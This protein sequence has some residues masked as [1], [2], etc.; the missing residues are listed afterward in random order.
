MGNQLAGIAPSQIFPVEHYLTDLAEFT[1][2]TNLGSTRFFKVAKAKHKEGFTVVKVFA[3]HDPSLPLSSHKERLEVIRKSLSNIPNCLP[4]QKAWLTEKAGILVRQFV[5]DNLYDRLSTRPFL[6]N[7][8]KRWIAFQL[9]D[10]LSNCHKLGVC[11]GDIK[12]ENV[13]VTGWNWV[14]LTDFASYKPTYL[15]EDNPADFSYFFDTSRRRTCYIAPERFVKTLHMDIIASS[16]NSNL[17][18]PEDEIKKGDLTPAMDIFSLGCVLTELFTDGNAP[19]DFSQLLAY[20]S[21]E[22]NPTKILDKIEDKN[23]KELVK[24]MIQKDPTSRKSAQ[25]YLDQQ[26]NFAFPDYFYSFLKEYVQGFSFIPILAPDDKI[27]RLKRDVKNIISVLQHDKDNDD[28]TLS[29]STANSEGLVIVVSLVTSCLRA[30]KHC[31]A[32]LQALEVLAEMAPF[33]APEII[34][35][36]LLP[37]MLFLLND[38]YPRVRVAAIEKLTYCLTLVK[39]IP[40]SDAN[41]FP[42]YIFPILSHVAQD[43]AVIVRTS[44]AENIA[45]I[46][47]TALRFLELTQLDSEQSD[48]SQAPSHPASYD[49]ELQILQEMVQDCVA[50]LLS[51]P[52]NV[53][54]QML[55]EQGITRL[56]VFFGRQKANDI[57]LSHMITFLNDKGD[58]NLRRVFF[59]SI[60][61]IAAY[62]GWQCCPILKPL[63]QQGLAD[64]EEFVI[65]KTLNSMADLAELGLIQK[66]MLYEFI[67]ET[68]PFLCHP[69]LWI[70]HGAVGFVCA[71]AKTLSLADLQCKLMPLLQPFLSRNVIQLDSEVV[72]LD[73][74]SEPLTREQ[75]DYLVKLPMLQPFLEDLRERQLSQCIVGTSHKVYM[76]RDSSL[77]TVYRRLQSEGISDVGLLEKKILA[78]SDHLLKIHKYFSGD[79]RSAVK[80]KGRII[81]LAQIGH[82]VRLHSRIIS[83]SDISYDQSQSSSYRKSGKKKMN[84][85][86]SPGV[87]MNE[88]WQ[89]MFG[90]TD[91]QQTKSDGTP[92]STSTHS[93]LSKELQ[94]H[95]ATDVLQELAIVKDHPVWDVPDQ[96]GNEAVVKLPDFCCNPCLQELHAMAQK[97]Q[98]EYQKDEENRDSSDI[99]ATFKDKHAVPAERWKPRGIL[100]AHLHEHRLAVNR[101]QVIPDSTLFATCSNDGSVKIWDCGRMDGRSIA[102]RSRQTYNRMEGH[103]T[104]LTVCQNLQSLAAASDAGHIHVF[105]VES[106]ST[107]TSILHSRTLEPQDEGC[108]VDMNYYDAGPQTVVV[109]ATVF[110]SIVGWDLRSPGTAWKLENHPKNGLITS[111]SIDRQHSWIIVGT[112]IGKLICWDMRFQLPITTVTHPTS[113]R[114]RK[115]MIHPQ[116]QS[117]VLAAVQGNNEVSQWDMETGARPMTLWASS[118]PPLSQTQAS[119]HSTYS[120]YI[121]PLETN[122]YLLTAGSDMRIRYWDMVHH[123][124]SYIVSGAA[125]DRISPSIV[126]YSSRYIDGTEVLQEFCNRPPVAGSDETP[127]RYPEIPPAGHHDVISDISVMQASQT[128]LLS[129]S[130]DGVVKVWK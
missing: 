37:Y 114:V 103:V 83:N 28:S 71:V 50:T 85:S 122:P 2:D 38:Q 34:L 14:L 97:K 117:T 112:A 3:I 57:L 74:I 20:R 1:Y 54:K 45:V 121:N 76:D 130:R 18:L 33:L 58:R 126:S 78:F 113:V 43:D 102:N 63:L 31:S 115:L 32:K 95:E 105:R 52:D 129:A 101:L 77:K 75:F 127:R 125:N 110:G 65:S 51:D 84:V 123:S 67:G 80:D 64:P 13:M 17:L 108:V 79:A 106:G 60:V 15:P 25:T 66:Q 124:E 69:N 12:L 100:V 47:E 107:K 30:L 19:F 8:E 91:S 7:I 46:A 27:T 94:I 22:Y 24:N 120:L 104:S 73:A 49:S 96:K 81:D 89:H 92:L 56:C 44:F 21:G 41:I 93:D 35:D 16:A 36:R 109:Y 29:S 61:G 119:S 55:L 86:D 99:P 10:A 70:R 6:N 87:T 62:V 9:I 5:K 11:H 68:V 40:R 128:F 48:P 72:L 98:E 53:V 26:R 4:F 118:A 82:T 39:H 23:I 88:E 111:F 90:S 116:K 42:E 59:E